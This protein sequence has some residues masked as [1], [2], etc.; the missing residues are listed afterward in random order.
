[1]KVVSYRHRLHENYEQLQL[2]FIVCT[3]IKFG[4]FLETRETK[5]FWPNIPGFCWDIPAVPEKFEKQ[6]FV[7][8]SLPLIMLVPLVSQDVFI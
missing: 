3:L 5:L 7:F 8:N 2:H 4:M 6:K 1:M